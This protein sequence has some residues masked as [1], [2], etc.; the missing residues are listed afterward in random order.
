MSS[1]LLNGFGGLGYASI[2]MT[3]QTNLNNTPVIFRNV[4]LDPATLVTNMLNVAATTA[5]ITNIP[6]GTYLILSSL[7][8]FSTTIRTGVTLRARVNGTVINSISGGPAYIRAG[9][10][11]NDGTA[12]CYG[13]A[14]VAAGA[15]IGVSGQQGGNNGL[16]TS[17]GAQSVLLILRIQNS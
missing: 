14:T 2:N 10:G 15:T 17:Q 6:L 16:V 11:A 3:N 7:A 12:N 5:N 13:I 8:Q 4:T 9:S 1:L